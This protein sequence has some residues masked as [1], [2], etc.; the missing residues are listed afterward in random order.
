MIKKQYVKS[1]GVCKVTFTLPAEVVADSASVVG[2]FN[3]W[4]PAANPMQ[5]LKTTGGWRAVVDLAPDQRYQFRY[6]VNGSEW[7]NDEAADGYQTNEHGS[8]NSIV[9]TTA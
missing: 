5:K 8:E 3:Q 9:V 4:D 7:H 6:F 1:R 2:E